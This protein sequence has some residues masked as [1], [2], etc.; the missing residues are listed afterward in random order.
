MIEPLRILIVDDSFEDRATYKRLLV[1][2]SD[3]DYLFFEVETVEQALASI[4]QDLPDCILL[5]YQ[6]PD[7]DGLE[8]LTDLANEYRDKTPAVVMLTGEGNE[9]VAVQAMKD[10]AQDY[11]VK[12]EISGESLRQAIDNAIE[13]AGLRFLSKLR[14]VE[15]KR[16]A[17]TDEL[18]GLFGHDYASHHLEEETY[19]AE[20]YDSP[21]CVG[22]L[23]LD[24]F[25]RIIEKH[26]QPDAERALKEI[27]GRIKRSARV[28]DIV[29]HY[30]YT[31]FLIILPNT[32]LTNAQNVFTRIH[33]MIKSLHFVDSVGNRFYVTCSI[34]M[35]S[36]DIRV[37]NKDSMIQRAKKALLEAKN[38]GCDQMVAWN[39]QNIDLTSEIIEAFV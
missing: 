19:R 7:R 14:E 8:L 5:D 17:V 9:Q 37:K 6:L 18:T 29:S 31:Q 20:R 36:Y 32:S 30:E 11:L 34:G 24:Q 21:F 35:S 12:T 15:L 13:K 26:G 3:A 1:R 39:E 33:S 10:G 2:E 16:L 23:E 28:L 25:K 38:R 27:A 22:M 4:H